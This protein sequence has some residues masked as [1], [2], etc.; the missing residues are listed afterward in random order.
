MEPPRTTLTY[1]LQQLMQELRVSQEALKAAQTRVVALF[2]QL[3]EDETDSVVDGPTESAQ[4]EDAFELNPDFD[5]LL[6]NEFETAA[7]A[8]HY[9]ELPFVDP[10]DCFDE[11]SPEFSFPFPE[12]IRPAGALEGL[13][14]S[15]PSP[16]TSPRDSKGPDVEIEYLPDGGYRMR[17]N[18]GKSRR[19][20]ADS[21]D[22]LSS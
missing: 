7:R 18:P 9:V 6:R 2:E 8:D 5:K 11:E 16:A 20:S 12:T 10:Y 3:S 17:S 15:D 4:P 21:L 1:E 14:E 13:F 19:N 22:G